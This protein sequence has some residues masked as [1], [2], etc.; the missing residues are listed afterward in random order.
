MN[1][2]RFIQSTLE[3]ITGEYCFAD[4]LVTFCTGYT[5][6]LTSPGRVIGARLS[7]SI[8]F[9]IQPSR[10]IEIKRLCLSASP[11]SLIFLVELISLRFTA[12]PLMPPVLCQR[13][14]L[15]WWTVVSRAHRIHKKQYQVRSSISSEHVRS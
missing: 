11:K 5:G 2:S 13:L 14:I 9:E 15:L 7:R 6:P 1:R 8:S 12:L 10:C 4:V 3:S